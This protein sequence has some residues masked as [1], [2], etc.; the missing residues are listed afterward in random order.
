MNKDGKLY[1]CGTP[2]GNLDDITSRAIDVLQ[3]VDLVAAEDTRRT[4]Q[5]LKH[6][7]IKKTMVSYHEHNEKK[8]AE[9][10]LEKL[11]EGRRLAL[12]SDAGMP[13]ISDPGLEIIKLAI[14]SDI[15]VIP[16]PGPTAA[17]S[18]LVVSGLSTDRFVFEGFVPRKGQERDL[19]LERVQREERTIILYESPYRLKDTLKEL[20]PLLGERQVVVV[21]ELTKIHEDKI[22][23]TCSEIL[24][25]MEGRQ[26]KG[27]IVI[28]VE[29]R[30]GK[31]ERE[32][33]ED[34]SIVAHVELLMKNGYTKKKAIKQVARLRDL[35]KSDVYQEAI[36]IDATKY[37]N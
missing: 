25:N 29:G 35:P 6:L 32:G 31:E 1:I 34:L 14:D 13:G 12:V 2:I 8:R 7:S 11:K 33:W 15:E 20:D 5:L 24:T 21:R 3:R 9:E 28:V 22:H 36:V 16:I 23:G 19:S 26:V 37:I 4:G 27:E 10:L 30:S 17:I 18:A